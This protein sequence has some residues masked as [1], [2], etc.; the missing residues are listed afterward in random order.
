MHRLPRLLLVSLLLSGGVFFASAQPQGENSELT[1]D[2]PIVFDEAR[3][4]I[5]ATNNARLRSGSALLIADRIEFDRNASIARAS[6]KVSLTGGAFRALADSLTLNLESG[7]LTATN[8]RMGFDPIVAEGASAERTNGIIHLKDVNLSFRDKRPGEPNLQLKEVALNPEEESFSAK[9]VGLRVGRFTLAKIPR[10]KSKAREPLFEGK[11]SAG[12]DDRLGWHLEIGS[13]F[14]PSPELAFGGSVTGYTKRGV[15]LSPEANYLHLYEG[16]Y[17]KGSLLGGFISDN[18]DDRGTDVR[19]NPV[20]QER[21][22]AD[23][24]HLQRIEDNFRLGIQLEWRNDSET[25][26]DFR[27][28]LFA[29]R[30]WNDSFAE[31]GYEGDNL[32]LTLFSRLHANDYETVIERRPELSLDVPPVEWLAPELYHSLSLSYADLRAA[33]PTSAQDLEAGRYDL[34]HGIRRPFRLTPWLTLTPLASHRFVKYHQTEGD[35]DRHFGELG[36]DLRITFGANFNVRN[37]VWDIDGLR[38]D[39]AIVLSHRLLERL[40]SDS[41]ASLPALDTAFLDPNLRPLDLFDLRQTDAIAERNLFRLGLEN[42]LRTRTADGASRTLASLH[43]YQDL[44]HDPAPGEHTFD[45]LHLDLLL[46]PAAW[47]SLDARSK[48]NARSG[49]IDRSALSIRLRNGDLSELDLTFFDYRAFS[50]QYQLVT[51]RR[52]SERRIGYGGLR[53]D[54]RDSRFTHLFLGLSQRLGE[55]WDLQYSVTRRRG[56]LKEDSLEFDA[57]LRLFAF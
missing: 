29:N 49:K 18:G 26:R 19:G 39:A 53:F 14:H 15:L 6:G 35:P 55:S 20:R 36:T 9:G 45:E 25:F 22:F 42:H 17:S 51:K 10:L 50:E 30:Q 57:G 41:S 3:N 23:L 56:A 5:V 38:H 47:I 43:L 34:A 28:D 32:G 1:A 33:D 52:F 12:E 7:D 2:G 46:S 54:A 4:L 8:Y 31:I 44:L 13:V 48:L 37:E 16:G 40:D 21:G 27:R 11:V 24:E